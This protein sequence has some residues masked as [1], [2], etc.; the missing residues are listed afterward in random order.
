MA[1][2]DVSPPERLNRI[3]EDAGGGGHER[4]LVLDGLADQHTIERIAVMLRKFR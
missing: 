3:L 1:L 2:M 4:H